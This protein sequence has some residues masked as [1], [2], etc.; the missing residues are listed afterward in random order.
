[1]SS[2]STWRTDQSEKRS[3]AERVERNE[4]GGGEWERKWER[5]EKEEERRGRVPERPGAEAAEV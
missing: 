2:D 5:K 1:M 4:T 3:S